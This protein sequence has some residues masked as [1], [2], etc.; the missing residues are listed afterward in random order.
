MCVSATMI[1]VAGLALS[2]AGTGVAM[3]SADTASKQAESNLKFQAA[4]TAA[5]ANA[6]AGE[7]QVE[8]M[9]IRKAG[10]AQ[11]AQATAAAAASGIDVNSPTALK[12]DEEIGKNSEED[13][14]LTILNGGDRA[15]RMRQQAT[16][17]SQGAKLARSEGRQQQ[18]AT[19]L[20]GAATA[21]GQYSNWKKAG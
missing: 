10:K 11:R 3:Y 7:A 8:A 20:S 5:D 12:I 14:T 21:A 2:A 13:A 4:Q 1:A 15:A 9:R 19:L 6:A 17:D 16:F 18:A